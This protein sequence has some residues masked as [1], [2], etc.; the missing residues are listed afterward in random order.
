MTALSE[1][2]GVKPDDDRPLWLEMPAWIRWGGVA[3]FNSLVALFLSAID[4]GGPLLINW[5]F[6]QCV[7]LTIYGCIES[8]LRWLPGG[9]WRAGGLLMAVIA[10][11]ML[12]TGLALLVTGVYRLEVVISQAFWQAVAIGLL[13]GSGITL[14]SMFRERTLRSE[15]ELDAERLK[16]LEA[17]KARV[18][19]ELRLLQAQV[20]PHFLFNTLAILRGLIGRDAVAG[21]QLLDHLIDYLRAS[22]SHSRRANATLGDELALL[23]DYLTIMQF[24]MGERLS[25]RID[26]DDTLRGWALP[27]MLL[28]P[29]VENAIRHGL[30]PKTGPGQL[31]IQIR[32]KPGVLCLEVSDNGIGFNPGTGT[33]GGTG[34]ANVRARLATLYDGQA[35][36]TVEENPQ[37][38]VTATLRLPRS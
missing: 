35:R 15:R 9:I 18:E 28:Q 12:G 25:F 34:L 27:P 30:E 2:P 33:G 8:V 23:E 26:A 3:L 11:S 6:S 21:T 10:G 20:E 5:L 37:G 36:L 19:T 29:L 1:E 17:D 38:G 14:F 32:E 22:L 31:V 16:H 13:F 7:G 4:Y 24:R